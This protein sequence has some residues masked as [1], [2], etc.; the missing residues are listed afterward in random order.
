MLNILPK[1]GNDPTLPL[2]PFLPR[3]PRAR[4]VRGQRRRGGR[5]APGPLRA[6]CSGRSGHLQL[7]GEGEVEVGSGLG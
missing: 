1:I 4:A 3:C 6:G 2:W 7:E 5:R